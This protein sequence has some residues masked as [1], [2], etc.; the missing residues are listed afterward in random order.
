MMFMTVLW[1]FREKPTK[2]YPYFYWG[3]YA[4]GKKPPYRRRYVALYFVFG[5][6][7]VEIMY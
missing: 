7:R 2:W 4:Q 5:T 6:Y 1:F 3:K